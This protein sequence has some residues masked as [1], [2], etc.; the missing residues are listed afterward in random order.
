MN[1]LKKWFGGLCVRKLFQQPELRISSTKCR[2]KSSG[3]TLI[4]LLI[5]MTVAGIILSI[6]APNF[7]L[8]LKDLRLRTASETLYS[9]LTKAR[10]EALRTQTRVSLCRTGNIF[11]N[12]PDCAANVFGTSDA[13]AA[14]DW[15][16]GWLVYTS[17]AVPAPY[18]PLTVGHELIEASETGVSN[19]DVKVTSNNTAQ[20]Y[21]AFNADGRLATGSP[22]LAVCDDRNGGIHGYRISFSVN[23]RPITT[24]FSD[25]AV[26]N[27]NC[28]P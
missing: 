20:T 24:R 11:P 14:S 13:N 15:S 16:Y 6:V 21:I 8:L 28:T 27:R 18:N 26:A 22:V 25:L 7:N 5:V 9:S 3:F 17:P 19:R 2:N 10:N 1:F 12:D 23:G 4:E